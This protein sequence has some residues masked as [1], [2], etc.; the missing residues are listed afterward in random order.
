MVW[1]F[2]HIQCQIETAKEAVQECHSEAI[3]EESQVPTNRFFASLRRCPERSEGMTK[4][5]F[6]L[7]SDSFQGYSM[8]RVIR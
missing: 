1:N 3:A 7:F 5:V 2:F 4:D 6:K 8:A